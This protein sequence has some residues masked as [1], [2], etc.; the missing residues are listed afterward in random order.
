MQAYNFLTSSIFHQI[1][2]T[3]KKKPHIHP[4]EFAPQSP[5]I[6]AF[7]SLANSSAP[8]ESSLPSSNY[9]IEQESSLAAIVP[10][11][12][13]RHSDATTPQRRQFVRQYTGEQ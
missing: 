12:P 11:P 9:P 8:V 6:V 3:R 10:L 1:C 2:T 7:T 5:A 4:P 13:P